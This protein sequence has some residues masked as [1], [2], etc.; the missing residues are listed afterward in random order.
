MALYTQKIFYEFRKKIEKDYTVP[1]SVS[2]RARNRTSC[3]IKSHFPQT[4][5]Q[6]LKGIRSE[7]K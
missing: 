4:S 7:N 2:T 1:K 6:D 5:V 3:E